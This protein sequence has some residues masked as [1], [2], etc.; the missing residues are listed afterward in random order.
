[1]SIL[2]NGIPLTSIVLQLL[3]AYFAIRLIK[4]SG[5]TVSWIFITLALVLMSVRRIIVFSSVYLFQDSPSVLSINMINE[6]IGLV[7][8]LC[9]LCGVLGIAHIFNERNRYEQQ[10]R[11]LLDEKENLL[12]E[13]HHRIKNNMN[14]MKSLLSLQSAVL[15]DAGAVSALDDAQNRIESMMVLYDKLYSSTDY[16]T[17]S[18]RDYVISL[19][20]E[21]MDTFPDKDK[22]TV[23]TEIDDINLDSKILQ[24]LG[25]II[26]EVLTN[27]M[28]YAF[29]GR[30]AGRISIQAK[31]QGDI[32]HI[33][34]KDDGV[35][36]PPDFAADNSTSFGM[37]LIR[38]L[39]KQLNGT[40]HIQSKSG[41][42]I[43]IDINA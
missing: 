31:R 32:L 18:L 12:K 33:S 10:I 13:V 2:L 37:V 35:G 30:A 1:M 27:A 42:E 6:S 34:I 4:I 21:I 5:K 3:A 36:L 39:T 9:M 28:K 40:L 15:Q 14:T 25:I 38:E 8:S 29:S 19:T 24:P 22:V 16:K 20:E 43:A 7:L 26:N 11:N 17:L 41:T 23:D